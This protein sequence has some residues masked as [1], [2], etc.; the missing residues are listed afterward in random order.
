MLN[1]A[2]LA[3]GTLIVLLSPTFAA[4]DSISN[5]VDAA[6]P[7]AAITARNGKWIELTSEQWQFLRG[8]YVVN[9][10]TPAGLPYGDRAVLAQVEGNA[11]GLVFFIDG[12]RACTP[13]PIPPELLALI[14]E[15]A[16]TTINHEGSG[17]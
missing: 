17:L 7:K 10:N 5:C 4:G 8:I 14:S 12:E 2:I 1:R 3:I 13:M 15:V 6:V 11:G 9:P 16:T